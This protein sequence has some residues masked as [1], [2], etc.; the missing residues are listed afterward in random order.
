MA[1]YTWATLDQWVRRNRKFL[2]NVVRMSTQELID[3]AQTP[4]AKGGR[5]PVDTGFL[6]N[7][8]H[9]SITGGAGHQGPA[10]HVLAVASM[11]GGDAAWFEWTAEYA[12]YVNDGARGR[13]GEHFVEG[14]ADQWQGIVR[15]AAMR[16]EG[17]RL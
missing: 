12:R 1:R 5:M 3:I 14:A 13:A 17:A 7:S 2:D 10:S 6:R 16:A 8:L 9:S 15:R 4:K 11:K